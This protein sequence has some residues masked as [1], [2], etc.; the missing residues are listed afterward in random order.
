VI[1]GLETLTGQE[2]D[3]MTRRGFRQGAAAHAPG[4]TAR[5]E[6]AV[7]LAA[8]LLLTA[9]QTPR[10]DDPTPSAS[11]GP[12]AT[13]VAADLTITVDATGEGATQTFTLTCDPVG[14]DHPDAAAA[15]DTLAAAG[16]ADA[17]APTPRDVACTEQWGGPQ[18]ATIEGTVA[19]ER[20]SG[21]FD[22]T[23][24]CEISRWD[25]LEALFGPDA[26]LM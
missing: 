12:P 25:H 18:T 26:G 1:D 2:E 19:G 3:P 24:G 14:G 11:P 23:N 17:F 7:T 8:A 15:C 20:V 9:C 4:T 10:D 22:R 5:L 6:L 16:G 21:T 13:A